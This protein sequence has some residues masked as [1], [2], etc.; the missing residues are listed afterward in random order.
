MFDKWRQY[1]YAAQKY[2]R[3]KLLKYFLFFFVLYIVYNC[4][5]AFFFSVWVIN[6]DT[7]QPGLSYG[8]RLIFT[9]FAPPSFGR[10][11]NDDNPFLFKRGSI[12]LIHKKNDRE[13]KLPL[14]IVD[15]FVRFFTAQRAT[16]FSKDSSYYIKRVIALPG[17]EISMTEYVFR[18][19]AVSADGNTFSLTEF[20]LS[21]KPYN[22]AIPAQSRLWD[23]SVPFSGTMD[24][25]IL[26]QNECFVVSDDRGNTNDSRT[27]GPIS[28]S[29]I[30]ARAA[31]RIWPLNKI[32]LF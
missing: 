10:N 1:S 4:L 14:N 28:L 22:P 6:N 24:P 19:K 29:M 15:G 32:E 31:L 13:H 8:D 2:Q 5:T 21:D 12:V 26:G 3:H 11:K 20:E 7:M 23:E 25:I 27:W 9:S 17:D 18:V 30:T 16:V